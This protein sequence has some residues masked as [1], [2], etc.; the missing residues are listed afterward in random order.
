[1]HLHRMDH[2]W[3]YK[4]IFI[5]WF[6]ATLSLYY[7]PPV[8]SE[9]QRNSNR[10]STQ[11]HY[12]LI[13][14]YSVKCITLI[15]LWNKMIIF[16]LIISF[17]YFY[18][19]SF[20]SEQTPSPSHLQ[21]EKFFNG[22][23]KYIFSLCVIPFLQPCHLIGFQLFY[24]YHSHLCIAYFFLHYLYFIQICVYI[25][26][27]LVRIAAWEISVYPAALAPALV[28]IIESLFLF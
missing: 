23:I 15:S 18:P 10:S 9:L 2:L 26:S 16:L 11:L 4:M 17:S 6:F 8:R 28:Q 19:V 12:L 25:V 13:I 22:Y 5:V 24:D 27:S 1:M 7:L 14:L 20:I 21:I 3:D